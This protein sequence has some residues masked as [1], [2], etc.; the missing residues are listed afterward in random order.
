MISSEGEAGVLSNLN[1][2]SQQVEKM[3]ARLVE[4]INNELLIHSENRHTK[5]QEIPAW[6]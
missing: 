4:L 1:R 5:K 2:K 3:F 6:L